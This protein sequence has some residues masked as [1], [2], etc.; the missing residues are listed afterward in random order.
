MA[1][2]SCINACQGFDMRTISGLAKARADAQRLS[3]SR[4]RRLYIASILAKS[5]SIVHRASLQRLGQGH[6]A[7]A[8]KV[9]EMCTTSEPAKARANAQRQSQIM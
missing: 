4:L 2:Y 5:R 7:K 6:F 9:A 3:L 1:V 8:C